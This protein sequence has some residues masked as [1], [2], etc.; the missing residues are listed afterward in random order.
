V[1]AHLEV[2]LNKVDLETVGGRN[3]PQAF[4]TCWHND[5]GEVF[6]P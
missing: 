3:L 6:N 2:D 1:D 4:S 5:L